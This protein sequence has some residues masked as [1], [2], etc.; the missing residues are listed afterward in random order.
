MELY[1]YILLLDLLDVPYNLPDAPT[2]SFSVA[3]NPLIYD[4]DLWTL[5]KYAQAGA[6]IGFPPN[7][8]VGSHLNELSDIRCNGVSIGIEPCNYVM[9]AENV[10]VEFVVTPAGASSDS[11]LIDNLKIE[12]NFPEDIYYGRTLPTTADLKK[13]LRFSTSVPGADLYLDMVDVEYLFDDSLSERMDPWVGNTFLSFVIKAKEGFSFTQGAHT[14]LGEMTKWQ[15][16][17]VKITL[18]GKQN[19]YG[20]GN[21]SNYYNG[22]MASDYLFSDDNG[23]EVHI[24]WYG[25]RKVD[26]DTSGYKAGDVVT[27]PDNC[28]DYDGYIPYCYDYIYTTPNGDITRDRVTG[29]RFIY[30]ET[31][32]T[33]IEIYVMFVRGE[34]KTPVQNFTKDAAD[35][36]EINTDNAG[37]PSST[38]VAVDL[39]QSNE[40]GGKATIDH[41]KKALNGHGTDCLVLDISASAFNQ[42]V[43]PNGKVLVSFDL[44][45]GYDKDHVDFC[46]ISDDGKMERIPMQVDP[47]TGKCTAALE[48][49]SL[50]A[51]VKT[52]EKAEHTEH[53]IH[54]D[55]NSDGKC[56]G[57]GTAVESVTPPVSNGPGADT[58]DGDQ[59]GNDTPDSPADPENPDDPQP[60]APTG[61]GQL[62]DGTETGSADLGIQTS[63]A[64]DN[65]DGL[66]W[67][68]L[69]AGA[70]LLTAAAIFLL[71]LL[72]RKQS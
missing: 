48:H 31:N 38:I 32:G 21:S 49:F 55:G 4:F 40:E 7:V 33:P 58:P 15:N 65:G 1:R 66:L 20:T 5:P 51:I 44:P 43:Q 54:T 30:P 26:M 46:Y 22:Y 72:R 34:D 23:I 35:T 64:D 37:F 50:Y 28:F 67:I 56:D 24:F 16:D 9:P 18:N 63:P 57:C 2:Y 8:S 42:A 3:D 39:V 27:I 13:A 69:G 68:I 12:L 14:D 45:K 47:A 6:R 53:V 36:V 59:P 25:G 17:N 61:D 10:L 71:I 29:K 52:L 60:T 11:T 19:R 62:V 41:V 70:A